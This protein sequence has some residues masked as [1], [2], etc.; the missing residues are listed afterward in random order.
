MKK[1]MKEDAKVWESIERGL[2][3]IPQDGHIE[4]SSYTIDYLKTITE[5]LD[6]I[7][8]TLGD[9]APIRHG[10]W[11]VSGTIKMFDQMGEIADCNYYTCT[12]CGFKK[13]I[14]D[15]HD[16]QYNYCPNCGAKMDEGGN[17]GT[18]D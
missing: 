15:G 11:M 12:C 9:V 7:I 16:S 14:F 18:D 17:D 10:R 2:L 4:I 13:L 5:Q 6:T 8:C 3:Q 1:R